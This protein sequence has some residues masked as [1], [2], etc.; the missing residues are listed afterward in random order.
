MAKF[1]E[2]REHLVAVHRTDTYNRLRYFY[3]VVKELY[4]GNLTI[5]NPHTKHKQQKHNTTQIMNN[6]ISNEGGNLGGGRFI[7]RKPL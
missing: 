7:A 2:K 4:E 5:P 3:N 1:D 6:F